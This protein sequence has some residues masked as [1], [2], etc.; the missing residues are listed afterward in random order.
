MKKIFHTLNIPEIT[1]CYGMTE[2]SPV[3]FQTKVS[4][5]FQHKT[6]TVGSVVEGV[7]ARIVNDKGEVCEVG[8]KGEFVAKG[9]VVMQGYWGDEQATKNSIVDG[10]MKSGDLGV[11]DE[12]GY[13]TIVGRIKDMIIRGGENVY[14]KEIEEYI[15][16]RVDVLDVQV[17]AV[18][19][20][21][22]GEEIVA[23]IKV[24]DLEENTVTKE[25]ILEICKDHIAHYKIPKFVK[26]VEELP[27][28]V[29][30]KP[31]KYIMREQLEDEKRVNGLKKYQIR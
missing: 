20:D 11:F 9:W 3:S 17:V 27:L 21:K 15:S 28:T 29:T 7:E 6:Q 30:G 12:N 18:A 13:L 2:T 26:F 25:K 23:L 16:K 14:P 10:W 5:T 4:D 31:Q 24:N 19:D 22:F 1:N 8:E